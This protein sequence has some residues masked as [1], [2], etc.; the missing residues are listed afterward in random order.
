MTSKSPDAPPQSKIIGKSASK[1][2]EWVRIISE[3]SFGEVQN[4]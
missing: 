2:G 4:R 1:S 3:W